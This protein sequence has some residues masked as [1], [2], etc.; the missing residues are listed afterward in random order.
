MTHLIDRHAET[1]GCLQERHR[2]ERIELIQQYA[3]AYTI[4]DAAKILHMD[5]PSLRR[6]AWQYN[7]AFQGEKN[8]NRT[9]TRIE[10]YTEAPQT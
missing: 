10:S 9:A 6:Y 4:N 8:G 2:R 3:H 7:I 5:A 1:W